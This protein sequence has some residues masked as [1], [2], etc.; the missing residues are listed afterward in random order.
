MVLL[1]FPHCLLA[2]VLQDRMAFQALR[3]MVLLTG[4]LTDLPMGLLLARMTSLLCLLLEGFSKYSL[5][6]CAQLSSLY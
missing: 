3:L 2:I 1:D 4:L 6:V 5:L